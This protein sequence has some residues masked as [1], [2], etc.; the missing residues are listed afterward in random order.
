MGLNR[1]WGS[2]RVPLGQGLFGHLHG[3]RKEGDLEENE[4]EVYSVKKRGPFIGSSSSAVSIR[5]CLL[6]YPPSPPPSFSM[7]L[8]SLRLIT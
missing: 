4:G 6:S 3:E 7:K 2:K 8:P 1:R 5:A